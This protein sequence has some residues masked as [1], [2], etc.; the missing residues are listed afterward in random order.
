M[1][2]VLLSFDLFSQVRVFALESI[3][4][5]CYKEGYYMY[6]PANRVSDKLA[7]G[8]VFGQHPDFMKWILLFDFAGLYPSIMRKFNISLIHSTNSNAHLTKI[9]IS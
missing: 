9:V 8:H 3:V 5:R 4:S 1:S 6:A 2:W 7:G